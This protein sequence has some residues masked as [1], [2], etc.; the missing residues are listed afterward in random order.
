MQ[1]IPSKSVA[2]GR[3]LGHATARSP[4]EFEVEGRNAADRPSK[5]G[6]DQIK[7][8]LSAPANTTV[9]TISELDEGRYK[10]EYTAPI[11]GTYQLTVQMNGEHITGSPFKLVVHL[12]RAQAELCTLTGKALTRLT[13]GEVG[14]FTVGFIDKLG[15]QAPPEELDIRVKPSGSPDL[16]RDE[17]GELVVPDRVQKTFN[18]FDA[19]GS[20]DID[21]SELRLALAQLG[22]DGDRK[23][24]AV[25][26][27]RYD[28]DG[29]GL[30]IQEFTQ[31]VADMQM[32]QSTGYLLRGVVATENKGFRDVKIEVKVA[33][34]Y[35]MSIAFAAAA[36]G[37]TLSGSP[38]TVTVYPGKASP[39][40]TELPSELSN[41]LKTS[42]G[43]SGTFLLQ[44]KDQ[45]KNL[46]IK[47]GDKVRVSTTSA[48]LS[49]GIKDLQNGTYEI[50]YL[51]RESFA[52]SRLCTP[53][54]TIFP[55]SPTLFPPS[56][57]LAHPLPP[58]PTSATSRASIESRS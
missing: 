7:F 35:E 42:V 43:E 19:D 38:F 22:M 31:L 11:A 29:G 33:G 23:A 20:G 49:A 50:S 8:K 17:E 54:P 39:E 24:A 5:Q 51:V 34:D 48:S 2:L 1:T 10:V 32:A 52:S 4:A 15:T 53:S 26:L 21:F 41:G 18:S 25:L 27:R 57:T 58:P 36:G 9:A 3:N 30:S 46:S 28:S 47:G 12:P 44:A 6:G 37:G 56:P 40:T 16:P 13:A 14:A 45:F 55:P